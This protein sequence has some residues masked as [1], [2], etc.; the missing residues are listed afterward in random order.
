MQLHFKSR[1]L[2]RAF[3]QEREAIR[4]WGPQ[5][6]PRYQERVKL[7]QAAASLNDLFAITYLHLHPLTGD[8]QG[9]YAITLSGRWRLILT[10]EGATVTI[11]EVSAHYGN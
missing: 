7:I 3:E 6:G 1:G 5:V 2:Q 8:R 9:Q 11:E 10:V 4:E